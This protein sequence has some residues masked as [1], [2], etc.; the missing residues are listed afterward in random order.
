MLEIYWQDSG[1][2]TYDSMTC[3]WKPSSQVIQ[4]SEPKQIKTWSVSA[5]VPGFAC[6]QLEFSQKK[7]VI[8]PGWIP[9]DALFKLAC[10]L[11]SGRSEVWS[12]PAFPW[13]TVSLPWLFLICCLTVMIGNHTLTL[14]SCDYKLMLNINFSWLSSFYYCAFRSER[15]LEAPNP[16][17]FPIKTSYRWKL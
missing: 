10:C 7:L 6:F 11:Y 14:R 2:T 13:T 4:P 8:L 12:P 9:C 1:R 17:L 16:D 15:F 5:D 3:L